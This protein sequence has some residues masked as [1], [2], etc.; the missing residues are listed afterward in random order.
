MAIID[1]IKHDAPSDHEFVWK[2][3]NG[4]GSD[5]IRLGSQLI[6]N[7]AQEVL[8]VKGGQ[9]LDLF[10]PGTHTLSTGNLPLLGKLVNLPFGGDTPFTAEV[11][12]VNKHAKRDLGWGTPG[13]LQIIDPTYGFPVT[14][15]AH[16][17]WG[18]RIEDS[19][20]FIT[21]LVGTLRGAD[22][23]KITKYLVGE[24]A[25]RF[26]DAL[27]KCLVVEKVTVFEASTK[28]NELSAFTK[29]AI[30]TE[31]NR[32]G[33][34]IVNFN[35]Q[36]ISI[37]DEE[38]QKFQEAFGEKLRADAIARTDAGAYQKMRAFDTL[39]AAAENEGGAAGGLLAGGLGLGMGLGAGVPVGQQLGQALNPQAPPDGQQGTPQ[40]A[41]GSQPGQPQ[42]PPQAPNASAG[43]DP[44]AR[45]QK[46]KQMLDTGL[47]SQQDFDAKKNDILG[48]L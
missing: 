33:I 27:A 26:S 47:I 7:Q 4:H 17:K 19:R 41:G 16:G 37:P 5:K 6:V 21:Q 42:P 23:E 44:M 40:N 28:L 43:E 18:I 48:T 31:F 2:Y 36:R 32:F 13:P 9:A 45:L 3:E 35:V 24:I 20:S 34:E 11:W 12:F 22:S 39:Q 30:S 46:L 8:F 1:R 25:Q 29:K 10:G 38:I 14:V 15:R